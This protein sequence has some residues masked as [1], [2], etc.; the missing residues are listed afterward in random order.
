MKVSERIL[1]TGAAGFIGAALCRSL[2][3]SGYLVD[4]IDSLN[5]YYSV[6]LKRDRLS[7]LMRDPRFTFT[8]ADI[9]DSSSLQDRG[10]WTVVHLAAQAGVRYSLENPNAYLHSNLI[11]FHNVVEFVRRAGIPRFV[12]ASSSSVYGN[13]AGELVEPH[14]GQPQS[15]Y[16]AT[17]RSN[18]LVASTYSHLYGI[19]TIGLRFFTVYGPWGRPDMAPM[20]FTRAMLAGDPIRLFNHGS[21]Y[22]DFTYIDDIVEG[23]ECVLRQP[24]VK[25]A[26]HIFNIGRGEK[27]ALGEFVRILSE[28]L[29]I[30]PIIEMAGM[31]PGDVY[32]T[33]ADITA[34]RCYAHYSPKISLKEG[35]HEFVQWYKRYYR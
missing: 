21:L 35:I 1:V 34:L 12:Y 25:S 11:G 33:H 17:K 22:R 13:Q 7:G 8:E 14:P 18:E 20:L 10:Y 29:G 19:N 31:Q 30:S 5:D 15:L 28:E 23:M 32:S 24:I 9:A 26:N 3:R 27:M 4:G 16:A 6:S 2:M